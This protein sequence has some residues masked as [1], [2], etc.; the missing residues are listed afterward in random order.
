M[1]NLKEWLFLLETTQGDAGRYERSKRIA[2][3][4]MA[5]H[6]APTVRGD[7]PIWIDQKNLASLKQP[8]SGDGGTATERLFNT[9]LISNNRH[10]LRN[11]FP[12]LKAREHDHWG[13]SI[14]CLRD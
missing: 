14:R 1:N 7:M 8:N 2:L 6:N 13:G 5:A 4:F 10:K 12:A 9:R 3:T 11:Q